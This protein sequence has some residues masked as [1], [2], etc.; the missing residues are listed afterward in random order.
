MTQYRFLEDREERALF[1]NAK[2]RLCRARFSRV[3]WESGW[4]WVEGGELWNYLIIGLASF[5]RELAC[6]NQLVTWKKNEISEGNKSTMSK[7]LDEN[8]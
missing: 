5:P 3:R 2:G 7:I 6:H 1:R 4:G 8:Y